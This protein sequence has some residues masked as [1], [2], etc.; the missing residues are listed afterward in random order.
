MFFRLAKYAFSSNSS[1]AVKL[2]RPTTKLDFVDGKCL[3]FRVKGMQSQF[4]KVNYFGI[5]MALVTFYSGKK[6][7]N[8]D[9]R[10]WFGL[11]FFSG[12]FGLCIYIMK[13]NEKAAA[14]FVMEMYLMKNGRHVEIVR[15][16]YFLVNER[17][18]VPIQLIKA[19]TPEEMLK[20]FDYD[21]LMTIKAKAKGFG[22][23]YF[24]R[25][26]YVP[27][28]DVMKAILQGICIDTLEEG[29]VE[30]F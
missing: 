1:K 8:Y 4:R 17:I 30:V 3:V 7:Y 25:E 22:K 13:G 18:L 11:I 6:V 5:V 12:L 19:K 14:K 16:R 20:K 26:S 29:H 28:S 9:K 10:G 24:L 2:F 15:K 27:E 21:Y 23:L